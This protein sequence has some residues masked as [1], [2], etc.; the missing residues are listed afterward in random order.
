MASGIAFH[1][2]PKFS[3]YGASKA[4]IRSFSQSLRAELQPDGFL[5]SCIYPGPIQSNISERARHVNPENKERE[6]EYLA[7]KG[8]SPDQ[9]AKTIFKGLK[10]RKKEII[11]G[12]EVWWAKHVIRLFPGIAEKYLIKYQDKLP[13]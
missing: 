10:S 4:G 3:A 1:G 5:V 13:V 11:L 8:Y 6:K 7:V 2:I 9:L 12:K